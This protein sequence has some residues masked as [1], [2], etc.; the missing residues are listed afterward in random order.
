[1]TRQLTGLPP[2]VTGF[3]VT[4]TITAEDFSDAV[5]P[6]VETA[7]RSGDVRFMIVIPQFRGMTPGALREDLRAGLENFQKWKR[8]ALVTDI[9]WMHHMTSLSASVNKHTASRSRGGL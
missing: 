4:G 3:E 7:A 6:A 2:G 8:I 5:L 1:M 9:E